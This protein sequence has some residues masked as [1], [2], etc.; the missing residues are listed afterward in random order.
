MGEQDSEDGEDEVS[1][2]EDQENHPNVKRW[3]EK[4][5]SIRESERSSVS[6]DQNKLA[7][8]SRKMAKS[9]TTKQRVSD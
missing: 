1:D 5:Q 8:F 6:G 3:D 9:F 4:R 2:S 7:S